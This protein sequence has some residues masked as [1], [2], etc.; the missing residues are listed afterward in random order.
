[1]EEEP[2]HDKVVPSLTGGSCIPCLK[3]GFDKHELL[4][5]LLSLAGQVGRFGN[6]SCACLGLV[7][8]YG[9]VC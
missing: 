7:L 5:R 3:P 1:M 4:L 6:V 2:S 8:L 9:D